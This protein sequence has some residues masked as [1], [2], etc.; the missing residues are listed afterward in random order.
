MKLDI[1]GS[2]ASGKSTL[3][4]EISEKYLIPFYEKDN[5]V[6]ERTPNGD[7]KR[8]SNERDRIFKEIIEGENWIVEGSPRKCLQESF[9]YS[10][11]IILLDINTSTRLFRVF[12]RWIR[13][14]MGK[15][16]YNSKPTFKFLYCNIK[17]VFEFNAERKKLIELLSKYGT[18]YIT[19]Y[20]L[21]QAM[22]F[23]EKMYS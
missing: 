19:F 9:A 6:W 15:E 3:A 17:W 4:R 2:V 22:Q 13:Q 14:R 11:Y 20:S 10:D 12:R 1:I 23:I 8:S 5:I 16:K 7:K 18:K 21:G